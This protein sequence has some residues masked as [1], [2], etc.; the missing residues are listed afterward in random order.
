[1]VYIRS[2][3]SSSSILVLFFSLELL[4]RSEDEGPRPAHGQEGTKKGRECPEKKFHT[5]GPISADFYTSFSHLTAVQKLQ[6]QQRFSFALL[7]PTLQHLHKKANSAS[8]VF[9][10]V[11]QC[12]LLLL[13]R[14]LS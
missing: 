10:H 6:L 12:L 5:L 7:L 14:S 2:S 1:M 8:T 3:S 4:E 11:K 9:F 13:L